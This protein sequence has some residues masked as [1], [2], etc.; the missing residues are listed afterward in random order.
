MWRK[1][2]LF[3]LSYVRRHLDA[4]LFERSNVV[5]LLCS[6]LFESA[7][8]LVGLLEL[9]AQHSV[10]VLN[11]LGDGSL[12]LNFTLD[13]CDVV[14]GNSRIRQAHLLVGDGDTGSRHDRVALDCLGDRLLYGRLLGGR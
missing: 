12:A 13:R 8:A 6:H 5:R 3:Q 10:V 1:A 14:L 4:H 7:N 2:H 9:A 11:A